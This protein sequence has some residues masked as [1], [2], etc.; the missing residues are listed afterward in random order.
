MRDHEDGA[1][2]HESVEGGLD[3][4]LG[5]GIDAGGGFVEEEDGRVLEEGAGDGEALFFAARE[6][7]AA[8]ADIG[9][10]L[11]GE[12]FDEGLATG[13]RESGPELFFGS[14]A[15]GEEEVFAHGAVEEEG[16]LSHVA[17]IFA[18]G[19][20]VDLGELVPIDEDAALVVVIE[21]R[22]EVD[23][24]GFASSGGADESDGLA[25][26]GFEIEVG[27]DGGVVVFAV[28]ER[29]VPELNFGCEAFRER[30]GALGVGLVFGIKNLED[31]VCGSSGREEELVE[32]SEVV[33]G[34]VEE[35][36]EQEILDHVA[37]S[38]LLLNDRLAAEIENEGVAH[39]LD[40][41]H[42]RVVD[43]PPAHEAEGGS[44]DLVRKGVEVRQLVFFGS[45]GLDLANA[46]NI[47]VQ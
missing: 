40:K 31:P 18:Q 13:I 22:Q 20:F 11:L 30:L 1:V 2:F 10:E 47:V 12:R 39:H 6:F 33:D 7:D 32:L 46:G 8:L 15:A 25:G 41:G 9:V 43:S 28:G 3:E 16:L 24:G 4:V 36:E 26:E 17:D 42:G 21:A 37:E 34:L 35:G 27:E 19:G 44:P 29:E 5:L 45:V 23:D 38:H 14:V